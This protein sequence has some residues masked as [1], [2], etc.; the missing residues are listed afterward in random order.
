MWRVLGAL[1]VLL[2]SF[3]A[4]ASEPN[5]SGLWEAHVMG[6]RIEARIDQNKGKISGVAYIFDPMGKKVTY[7]FQGHTEGGRLQVTHSDGH[8]FSGSLRQA[9]QLVGV[10]K[11][12]SGWEVP[13]AAS[14]R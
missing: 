5:L 6:S 14:R 7:H 13:V 9:N 2:S 4:W 1:L 11:A 12:A 3:P 8:V 10:I